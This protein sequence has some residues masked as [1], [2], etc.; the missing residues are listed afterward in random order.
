MKLLNTLKESLRELVT[1][2]PVKR[3]ELLRLAFARETRV[4]HPCSAWLGEDNRKLE[5]LGKMLI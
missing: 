2:Y 3:K 5:Y 4:K 1:H